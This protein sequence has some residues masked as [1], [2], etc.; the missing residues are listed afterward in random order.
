MWSEQYVAVCY[1]QM[2]RKFE[3]FNA[4]A[5]RLLHMSM[6]VRARSVKRDTRRMLTLAA[7]YNYH[8]TNSYTLTKI[9]RTV[10]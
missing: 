3:L 8:D 7:A 5:V 6:R 1:E 4:V 10:L 2:K 9:D